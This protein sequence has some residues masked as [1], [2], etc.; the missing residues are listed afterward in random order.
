MVVDSKYMCAQEPLSGHA[1]RV[2]CIK[3][4]WHGD[5][6]LSGGADQSVWLC[7]NKAANDYISAHRQAVLHWLELIF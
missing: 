1:H 4:A 3:T 5:G 6:M 2:M 7:D